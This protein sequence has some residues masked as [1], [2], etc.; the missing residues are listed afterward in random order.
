[1]VVSGW[2]LPMGG[3]AE[4]LLLAIRAGQLVRG[5]W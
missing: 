2:M 1:M 4:P 5:G 3:A